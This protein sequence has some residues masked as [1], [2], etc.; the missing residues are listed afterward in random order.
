ML[1]IYILKGKVDFYMTIYICDEDV[2][3]V[4]DVFRECGISLDYLNGISKHMYTKELTKSEIGDLIIGLSI[5]FDLK[6]H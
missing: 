4:F 6:V 2:N 5:Y 1:E 3:L